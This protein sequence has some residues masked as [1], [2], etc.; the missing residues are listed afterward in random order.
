[1]SGIRGVIKKQLNSKPEGRFRAT[2]EDKILKSDIVFLKTWTQVELN[3]YYN[4][5]VEYD[6]KPR[7]YLRTMAQLRKDHGIEL[8]QNLNFLK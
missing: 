6:S 2:F 8:I 4:P 5:I 7:K 1:M 3:K